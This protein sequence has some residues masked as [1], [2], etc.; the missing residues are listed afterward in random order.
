MGKRILVVRHGSLGDVILSSAAVLNLRLSFP[1]HEIVFATKEEFCPVAASI[2]GVDRIESIRERTGPFSLFENL[3]RLDSE[4]Y[5]FVVDLHRKARTWLMR[6]TVSA[7]R[8]VIYPKRR[9][10][11]WLL[12]RQHKVLP[13]EYPHTIDLYNAAV[14]ELG[15][16][17]ICR[18]PILEPGGAGSRG[19][20]SLALAQDRPWIVIA[21]GAAHPTKQWPAENFARVAQRLHETCGVGVV[22]STLN[23]TPSWSST[24]IKLAPSVLREIDNASLM[25]IADIIS[26]V[27]VVIANDSGIAHLASALATPVVALFGPTHPVLG[28]APQGLRDRVVEVDE[29]C[30]PCSLHGKK[31]CWRDRRYC[32]ERIQPEDVVA[33]AEA[34]IADDP[35][36]NRAL[37]VDRDGTLIVDKDYASDPEQIE[38]VSGAVEALRQA[39]NL[40]LKIVITSNQSGVARGLFGIDAVERMNRRLVRLLAGQGVMADGVYYCPHHRQGTVAK[41]AVDCRCRKPA[42]GMVEEAA[43][44]LRLDL[45]RSYVVG[46]KLDDVELGM[47]IGAEPFLVRTGHGREH[48]RILQNHRLSSRVRRCDDLPAA[49]QLIAAE[50]SHDQT[51]RL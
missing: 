15:G 40:G 37:F 22:W 36:A 30:R 27:R 34:L 51:C 35:R 33:A 50:V 28:F 8:T 16:R 39:Q 2:P 6:K 12:T 32:L 19:T 1:E 29:F 13:Y 44:Q 46:D 31:R 49:V 21:P 41:F 42:P 4:D 17:V 7:R 25:D 24:G 45:R 18:R 5:D 10:E 48:E 26:L 23:G 47:V 11:R 43:L 20:T 9:L 3:L 14:K 38:F